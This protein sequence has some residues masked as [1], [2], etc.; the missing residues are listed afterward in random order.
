MVCKR[1]SAS[2]AATTQSD[3]GGDDELRQV[4]PSWTCQDC[5]F[6]GLPFCSSITVAA[7]NSPP[8]EV[9][10]NQAKARQTIQRKDQRV[11]QVYVIRE[12]WAFRY[13]ITASGRRQILS[14][15]MPGDLIHSRS[16]FDDKMAYSVQ[17]ITDVA[18]CGFDLDFLQKLVAKN[19]ELIRVLFDHYAEERMLSEERLIDLGTRSAEERVVRFLLEIMRRLDKRGQVHN[20]M[21]HLPLKQ[22]HLADALGLTQVHVNR[23]L[24]RL[25]EGGLIEWSRGVLKVED[26]PAMMQIADMR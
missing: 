23:V 17:S 24:K 9:S 8:V 11:E 6:R 7:G 4:D 19:S 10:R 16:L 22:I 15:L 12:G 21:F 13:A 18:Y 26:V 20:Q 14:F 3:G 5:T 25:R 2:K 1:L